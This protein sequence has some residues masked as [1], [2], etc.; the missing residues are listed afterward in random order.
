[1]ERITDRLQ[2]FG[3]RKLLAVLGLLLLLAS[4]CGK[5]RQEVIERNEAFSNYI[6]G[7]TSNRISSQGQVVVRL[8]KDFKE[9]ERTG[10][11]LFSFDPSVA[12]SQVWLDDRTVAFRPE[13]GF[14]NGRKY[15]ASFNA[16]ALF[17]VDENLQEFQFDFGIIR[18]DLEVESG[19]LSP[20][21]SGDRS[22]Q[23]LEGTI[24]TADV[25]ALSD[26]K[27][28]LQVQQD[29]QNL[30]VEWRQEPGR[31]LAHFTV[32]EIRRRKQAGEVTL[33]WDGN[34]IGVDARGNR[35]V[36]VP[37]LD[38]FEL[39]QTEVVR[40]ENPHV[41]LVF[42]DRLDARQDF[43][44]LV[45]FGNSDRVNIIV[46]ENRLE[47]YPRKELKGEQ[48]LHLSPGI[49]SSRGK[50][51]GEEV[52]R[53]VTL[54]QPKPQVRFVG[55]GVIIPDS[56]ELLVPFEAVSLGAVD[57]QVTRIFENNVSQFLQINNLDGR[58]NLRRVGRPVAQ[59]VIPLSTLGASDVS[60]WNGYA[61][62]LSKLIKPE[63]GAVYQVEIGF[64]RHQIVYPCADAS[65]STLE[66]RSWTRSPEEESQY[67]DR[68][69]NS[70][71][72]PEGYDWRE[73]DN[74]CNVSYYTGRQYI[75][76]NVLASDLGLIAKRGETGGLQ[77]MVTDLRTAQ[78]KSG[79]ALEVL[80]YQQQ[81]MAEGT[82]DQQG[83]AVIKT[84]REPFLLEARDG[85]QR[86]YLKLNEGSALS[87]S[88]FD[89]SGAQ[90]KEGIKGYLYGERGVWRPGD[91]LYVTLIVEDR[92][93][94][95]PEHHPVTFELRDPNGQVRDRRTLTDPVGGFYAYRGKTAHDAP[96]GNWLLQARLGG[97]TFSKTL[98]IETVKPNRLKVKLQLNDERLTASDR[99]L[100]G[101][102]TARWLHGATARN[103]KTDLSMTLYKRSIHFDD[104]ADYSFDDPSRSLD[105]ATREI[106]KG[107]LENSGEVA[108]SHRLNKLQEVPG[109]LQA[110]L[111]T[112]VFEESGNFSVNRSSIPYY[113]YPT[114]VGVRLPEAG[115]RWGMLSRDSTHTMD[116][117]TL[118]VDGKPVAGKELKVEIFKVDWRWWWE[119][120]NKNLSRYFAR[121]NLKPIMR[122][123]TR[124]GSDGRS[125]VSFKIEDYDWG[126]FMVRVTDTEGG[127]A[128]GDTFYLGWSYFRNNQA[129]NPARL[130]FESDQDRY[131]VG[132]EVTLTI[133][134]SAGGKALVSLETGSRILDTY[135]VDTREEQ[136]KV[137]FLAS[138]AMAPNVYAHVMLMQPHGQREN[139]RPIRM[140]G[141][142]PIPVED[143]GTR[144]E[145]VLEMPS[146][147][148]PETTADIQVREQN[149]R[150]M[151]YTV[152]VVDEG[153]LDLTNFATP[154]PHQHFYA[155]EALGVRT[156][157]I[158]DYVASAYAGSMNRILSIGGDQDT[159]E[160][161]Q[162][163]EINRFEPMV[164]YLGPFHLK[165]GAVGRHSVK[166]PNYVG[167]V[168]AMVVAGQDGAYGH[169]E[170]A[171][172]VR[173][174]VMVLGTLPR[175][176]GPGEEVTLP[177]SVFAMNED[178]EEVEV[179]VQA[180]DIFTLEG[181]PARTV[182]FEEPGEKT[183][184]F[185]L[186]VKSRIGAGRVQMTAR[187]GSE[188]ARDE[189]NIKVRN[190][191][192]PVT[193]VY[194]KVLDPG[195]E[196]SLG[197]DPAGLIG[198]N[199]GVFEVS[200]IP[201]IDLGR[202]LRYL[203]R[204]PHGCIEQVTSAAFP[205]LYLGNIMD[206]DEQRRQDIQQR[207]DKA[208]EKLQAFRVSS[209][210]LGYWPDH[211]HANEWGT[212]YAYHFLLEAKSKG[213][214]VPAGL[215]SALNRYQRQRAA[216]WRYVK[217]RSHHD[218]LVQVYRLYT[219]A[220][221][222]TPDLGAMNRM[223]ER[224]N[225]S[226]QATWRLAA[227]YQLAG[228]PEAADALVRGATT[229]VSEY[230]E[231]SY[232]YGSATRDKAM[233]LETLSLM[234]DRERAAPLMKEIAGKLNEDRWMSTQ[235]TAYSLIAVAR[236]L[237]IAR[238]GGEID[239]Q[240][241]ISS[242]G[243][244]A[245]KS[246]AA[247]SQVPFTIDGEGRQQVQVTN[248]GKGIVFARLIQEGVPLVGDTTAAS[249]NLVQKVRWL[250]LDGHELNPA[251]L[252]QGSDIIAEVTVS[253]PGIRGDY[254]D[255]ALAQIFPSGWEIRNSRMDA[256]SFKEPTA[257]PD[258]RDIRDDRVYT[259]F[260]LPAKSSKTFRIML[261]AS[262]TGRFYLPTVTTQAMYDH[263]ISA[264]T[265]GRWVQVVL[266][267]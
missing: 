23:Q 80:D 27:R 246:T 117:V 214:Y 60:D 182:T 250:D 112:R 119:K 146:E 209:G 33:S 150:A 180:N 78:P 245:V 98:K 254:K 156:W 10:R 55:K 213:Y 130:A 160:P 106:F 225:L 196:W 158:F 5:S 192:P 105:A 139:D 90:V 118:D 65:L 84:D 236:F 22:R 220:L 21:E 262:Y 223:R 257:E 219:L 109:K 111:L 128:A 256:V 17:D 101:R 226:V 218:D 8:A 169:A 159:Q 12:G 53:T 121:K 153:L 161:R 30:P 88:D 138:K 3:S 230:R 148:R 237:E 47:V 190:P 54:Q 152:A 95:L 201:P 97:N 76:R 127:H 215:M 238:P 52:S 50:R 184:R 147:L 74:P 129:G 114:L 61:L 247:L 172:P 208:I 4:G 144:L 173:K 176:L 171:V 234:G 19:R 239:V 93:D 102:I 249:N 26:L 157:D 252:P 57:V 69:G 222:N 1:M 25:A 154:A 38:A 41:E 29:G 165:A 200:R 59:E 140:Y 133:P 67:W 197:Y 45:R 242:A 92:Q 233:I 64:R 100:D 68:F 86:G 110:S 141:V 99:T 2:N 131:R 217:E 164:R 15:V 155:R 40:N 267:E 205:Q 259:Y 163:A 228:Q 142:I 56:D 231:M 66:N 13:K 83:M 62:D 79:V 260:D 44:G 49:R 75:R 264:R 107:E 206:L 166:I 193:N 94:V 132:E 168:R 229:N 143:P 212:S 265:P 185:N 48:T 177:V 186:Q 39:V 71:Y 207:V 251:R 37:S 77:V 32:K 73:R 255:L 240:Y 266:P 72:Y 116:L 170:K 194:E 189:I 263:S 28:V 203:I 178:I 253:N 227:A 135:W 210:G 216:S 9:E 42:S 18:Q 113:P 244:G 248:N 89:V 96:T 85:A 232:T 183:I 261:N 108:F 35:T 16:G 149:G 123:T 124:T 175:V 6:T 34:P 162:A 174:P 63:P 211:T 167:S 198:T 46:Q 243:K 221:A 125:K 82:T 151:T 137:S 204:Y 241:D 31:R 120:S 199:T 224:D 181:S 202:R 195:D 81:P 51:L 136:T 103:L 188:S 187:S 191:N 7:Y 24:H 115:N 14:E 58:R 258:Y 145:P 11:Q 235:T 43:D 134:S 122:A 87:L 70:Y 91:S 126:R 104:Y 20:S 179:R 36:T